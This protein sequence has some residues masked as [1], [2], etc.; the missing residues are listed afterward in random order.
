VIYGA[1]Y[2]YVKVGVAR[3]CRLAGARALF[4]CGAATQIGSALGSV[5][6]FALVNAAPDIFQQHY[7]Q[8]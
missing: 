6:F 5:L 7:V 8:C 4:W 3:L 1:L 2:S